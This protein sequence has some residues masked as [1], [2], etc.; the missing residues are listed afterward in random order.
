ML[1]FVKQLIGVN[2][3]QGAD[4]LMGILVKWNPKNA[5]L[6]ERRMIAETLSQFCV[7]CEEARV[8]M[9]KEVNDV[10]IVRGEAAKKIALAK[11]WQVEIADPATDSARKA[12]LESKMPELQAEL[13][14][15][16]PRIDKEV[17]EA[18][19]ATKLFNTYDQ[20]VKVTNEKLAQ[21]NQQADQAATELEILALEEK[22]AEEQVNAAKVLAGLKTATDSLDAATSAMQREA[23]KKRAKIAGMTREAE[24]LTAST[25]GKTDDFIAAELADMSGSGNATVSL[26]DQIAALE[27][28]MK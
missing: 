4:A 14:A 13:T 9:Q 27:G 8:K 15:F 19:L 2:A 24:L 21:K 25:P 16:G 5:S 12:Q 23:E 3:E 10:V 17:R 7:K 22:A 26:E 6:A 28:K 1:S 18:E 11:K 20:V